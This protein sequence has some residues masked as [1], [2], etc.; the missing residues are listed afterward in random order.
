MI[1]LPFEEDSKANAVFGVV[2]GVVA[3]PAEEQLSLTAE[4]SATS[5]A[6]Q[7]PR[8]LKIT[9]LSRKFDI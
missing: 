6:G 1:D 5:V 7:N 4:G 3:A 8:L 2:V 9:I